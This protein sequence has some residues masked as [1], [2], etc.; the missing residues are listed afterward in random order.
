M[1]Q[2]FTYQVMEGDAKEVGREEARALKRVAPG[3]VPFFTNPLGGDATRLAEAED[4]LR[5]TDTWCPGLVPEI[6]GFAKE[7]GTRPES[8]VWYTATIPHSGHCSHFAIL[9]DRSAT[10]GVICGRSYEWSLEDEFTLR[11][12]RVRGHYGHTGFGVFCFGRY[13]GLNEKGLWVSMSAGNPRPDRPLPSNRG[14]RFWALLRTILDRAA[15]VDEAIEIASSF[16]LAF[17]LNLIV[18]DRGGHAALIEKG[19]EVQSV[20]R[21]DNGTLFSTNHFV[22]LGT[23]DGQPDIFAHSDVRARYLA[24]SLAGGK[25]SADDARRIL[26]ARIPDGV[27]AHYYKEYFGT[28]WSAYAD[29][30]AGNFN[31]CFGAPDVATNEFLPFRPDDPVGV[32][33]YYAELPD[34]TAPDGT[35]IRIPRAAD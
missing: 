26:S 12:V 23:R 32:T 14:F 3:A 17:E 7:L 22:L 29:L 18:A 31:V 34:E 27:V 21:A 35:W 19:P 33:E 6:E 10:G 28:L 30:S 1:K 13:D 16:P 24:K 15:S 4:L 11:T 2:R 9:P 20:R 8:V 5:M 25:L